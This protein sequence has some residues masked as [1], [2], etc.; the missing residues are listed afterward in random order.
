M[1][2]RPNRETPCTHA[3]VIETVERIESS[4]RDTK[5]RSSTND[6]NLNKKKFVDITYDEMC[7]SCSGIIHY[8]L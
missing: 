5:T 4:L 1:K 7:V 2:Q 8:Y 3:Q 6:N